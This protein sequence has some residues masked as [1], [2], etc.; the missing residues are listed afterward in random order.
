MTAEMRAGRREH[1]AHGFFGG[2]GF[3]KDPRQIVL[4]RQ[5]ALQLGDAPPHPLLREQGPGPSGEKQP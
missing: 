3:G 4:Q 5:A 1:A 2:R